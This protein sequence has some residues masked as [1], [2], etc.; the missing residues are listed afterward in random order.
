MQHGPAFVVDHLLTSIGT[1]AG[2]SE[3]NL[4]IRD[5]RGPI[6][7]LGRHVLWSLGEGILDLGH[8]LDGLVSTGD[9]GLDVL[10][11]H[12]GPM[13]PFVHQNASSI[14]VQKGGQPSV[15]ASGYL[16]DFSFDTRCI[17]GHMATFE[18]R[19][20]ELLGDL[21]GSHID[22]VVELELKEAPAHGD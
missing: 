22:Q 21:L 1:S 4:A 17:R 9:L 11:A 20:H 8:V 3:P 10:V 14:L 19:M 13:T 18:L 5:F 7:V 2:R 15:F 16:F 12:F 6:L